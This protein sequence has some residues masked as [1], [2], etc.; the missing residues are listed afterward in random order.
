MDRLAAERQDE[1]VCKYCLPAKMNELFN[2]WRIL[3]RSYNKVF[4]GKIVRDAWTY[5]KMR[6]I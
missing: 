6:I 4:C 3:F 1:A 5:Y 2:E